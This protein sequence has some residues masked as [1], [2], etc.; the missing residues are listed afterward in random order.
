MVTDKTG[1]DCVQGGFKE[2]LRAI[3]YI[4]LTMVETNYGIQDF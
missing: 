4:L 2:N 3:V 1:C